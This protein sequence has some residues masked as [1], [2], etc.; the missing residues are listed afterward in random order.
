LRYAS[1]VA[2]ADFEAE[3]TYVGVQGTSRIGITNRGGLRCTR[4]GLIVKRLIPHHFPEGALM[5]V[6]R[7]VF[8]VYPE[9]LGDAEVLLGKLSAAWHTVGAVESRSFHDRSGEHFP[10]GEGY[11]RVI[12]E[13]ALR[14]NAALE[15]TY[16]SG[17]KSSAAFRGC[18]TDLH[19]VVRRAQREIL[20][21]DD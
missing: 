17:P 20:Q 7:D 11:P 2:I 21:P 14:G 10:G 5:I 13:T 8:E 4:T 9:R 12:V 19:G 3:G 16:M 18:W 6:V 1:T 15:A